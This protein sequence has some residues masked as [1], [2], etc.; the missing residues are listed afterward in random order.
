MKPRGCSL[1]VP[2]ETAV[3]S[4][5]AITLRHTN[6]RRQHATGCVQTIFVASAPSCCPPPHL[7]PRRVSIVFKPD[8]VSAKD[9]RGAVCVDGFGRG[10]C[11]RTWSTA[12]GNSSV[13]RVLPAGCAAVTYAAVSRCLRSVDGVPPRPLLGAVKW[14]DGTRRG[15][16]NSR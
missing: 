4:G 6:R 16:L 12:A 1:I 9:V 10:V 11:R 14:R 15:G 3:D 8:S 5:T 7:Q 2:L 13:S